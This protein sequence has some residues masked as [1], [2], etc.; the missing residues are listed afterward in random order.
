MPKVLVLVAHPDLSQSR[1][2]AAL[3]DAV[4]DLPNVT[5]HDLYAAYPD[6]QVD[7]ERERALLAQHDVIVFQ[8]P[9]YWYNVTPMIR[10]WQDAVLTHGWAFTYDGTRTQ[11]AGKKAIVSLTIGGVPEA[12]T[13]EGINRASIESLFHN[14]QAT[15]NLCQFDVQPL[16]KMYGTVFGVSDED[17]ATAAKNFRELIAS[18]AA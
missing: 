6:F 10:H 14:W 9:V 7:G 16:V 4:R 12:Y 17:I 13:P 11:T 2:N 3:V 1:H 8:H 15:L 18:H 5:V